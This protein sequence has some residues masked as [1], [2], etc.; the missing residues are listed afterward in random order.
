[1]LS[2][3]MNT[4]FWSTNFW[5]VRTGTMIKKL[6][7]I[8]KEMQNGIKFITKVDINLDYDLVQINIYIF[9]FNMNQ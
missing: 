8:A 2:T 1:M 5:S 7:S 9:V 4:L 3:E 6:A